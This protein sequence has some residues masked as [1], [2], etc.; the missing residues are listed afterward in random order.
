MIPIRDDNPRR[1]FPIVTLG[2]V[3]LN[4]VIFV[5]QITMQGSSAR[6]FFLE[7]GAVP[8][9]IIQGQNLHAIFSSMFLHGGLMHLLGNMLYLWIFGDNIESLC[10]H[11][12]FIAFY[13]ICGIIAFL[14]HFALEP[15]SQVP[16]VGA[17]GAISGV[18]GAYAI[19]FPRASVH[20]LIPLFPIVWLWRVVRAPAALA[21]GVWFALQ[22]F[23]A[24]LSGPT[25][26]AWWAHIGGFIAGVVLIRFFEKSRYKVYYH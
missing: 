6:E 13:L 23:S 9:L 24:I 17:S 16:I 15:T 21:L 4:V 20:V 14:S 25:G 5:Y 11:L 1:I 18:L 7:F 8:A 22:I 12:R 2:I 26:V 3:I 10:G 19:R